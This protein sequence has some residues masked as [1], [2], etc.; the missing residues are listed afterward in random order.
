M[1]LSVGRVGHSD[2]EQTHDKE[3]LLHS[4]ITP[5][6]RPRRALIAIVGASLAVC[7]ATGAAIAAGNGDAATPAGT[8]TVTSGVFPIASLAIGLIAGPGTDGGKLGSCLAGHGAALDATPPAKD[9]LA[10]AIRACADEAAEAMLAAP[11]VTG[12]VI[13]AGPAVLAQDRKVEACLKSAGVLP[14]DPSK[15]SAPLS[16]AAM[17]A[18][19]RQCLPDGA[20]LNAVT[21]DFPGA[22][23]SG[24]TVAQVPEP[25]GAAG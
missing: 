14:P 15:N 23:N 9:A 19:F 4:I 25:A 1:V 17:K 13:V 3:H 16:E 7:G 24:V 5:T 12:E 11:A 10:A 21:G 18:A 22:A 2:R 20:Q 8:V 6:R